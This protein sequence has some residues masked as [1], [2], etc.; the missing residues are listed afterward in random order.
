MWVL[1]N[2]FAI[3]A[4]LAKANNLALNKPGM[5]RCCSEIQ[6]SRKGEG[7]CLTAH[8]VNWHFFEIKTVGIAMTTFV[9]VQA[10]PSRK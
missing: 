6:K 4:K 7:Y 5:K 1:H 3:S 8:K 2:V 9:F 10:A